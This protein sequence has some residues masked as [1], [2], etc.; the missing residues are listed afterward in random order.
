MATKLEKLSIEEVSGVENP[1][2]ETPGWLVM[3]SA[4]E[5]EA[6]LKEV[7]RMESD[8][9]IL[10]AAL[11]ACEGYLGDAPEDATSALQSLT[12]YVESL[13]SDGSDDAQPEPEET[14]VSQTADETPRS[15]MSMIF[16]D[17]LTKDD[18]SVEPEAEAVVE[19]EAVEEPEV[20]EAE[21]DEAEAED[22]GDSEDEAAEGEEEAAAESE[23]PEVEVEKSTDEDLVSVL[24]QI[25]KNQE[26]ADADSQAV[27]ASLIGLVERVERLEVRKTGVNPDLDEAVEKGDVDP[28]S[29][30]L[31]SALGG[32]RVTI[33]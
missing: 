3:K 19:D 23:E 18:D 14:P 26:K 12:A 11:K 25:V 4:D 1:A 6:L 5:Q 17:K 20:D 9:A 29:A 31:H 28:L 21:V 15:L 24:Q 27:R 8:F 32:N 16:G 7:D 33:N 2:N 30:A 13:F 22:S 10:Y